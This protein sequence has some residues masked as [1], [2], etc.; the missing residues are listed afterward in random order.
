MGEHLG[1]GAHR[2]AR[3][4]PWSPSPVALSTAPVVPTPVLPSPNGSAIAA[5]A[6]AADA[7]IVI[8]CLRNASAVA[9]HLLA[10]RVDR[11]TAVP[12]GE[13]WPDGSL[14]PALEDRLGAGAVV[15]ALIGR[16]S[17]DASPEA[18]AAAVAYRRTRDVAGAASDSVSGLELQRRGHGADVDVAVH[19]DADD[20]VP[21]LVA[22]AFRLD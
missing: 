7:Q 2:S 10:S 12:A 15:S 4:R 11:V 3:S 17:V 5:R 19:I 13:Q 22:G 18:G 20:V 1:H 6:S 8:G 14:R 21:R 16:T 9:R